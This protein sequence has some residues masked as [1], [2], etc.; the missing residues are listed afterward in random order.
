[1]IF[2]I[3]WII[4]RVLFENVLCWTTKKNSYIALFIDIP[5]G[6]TVVV[7]CRYIYTSFFSFRKKLLTIRVKIKTY[8]RMELFA[9]IQ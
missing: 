4:L 9:N 7:S 5:I 8:F 1:M 3:P 6:I 2:V